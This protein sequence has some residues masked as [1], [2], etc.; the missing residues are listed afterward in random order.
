[1]EVSFPFIYSWL[2]DKCLII[3]VYNFIREI[4]PW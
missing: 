1:M 2:P 3:P 4:T